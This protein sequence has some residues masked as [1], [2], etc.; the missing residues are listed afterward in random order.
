M[1]TIELFDWLE[2]FNAHVGQSPSREVL[3]L[4]DNCSSHE[5][6]ETLPSLGNVRIEFLP[7][8][9]TSVLQYMDAGVI[10]SLRRRFSKLQYERVLD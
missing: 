2:R 4:L 3:L 7:A 10:A 6:P 8:N 9:T 1:K 5:K